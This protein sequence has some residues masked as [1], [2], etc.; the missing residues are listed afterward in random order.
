MP[1]LTGLQ[2]LSLKNVTHSGP[3]YTQLVSILINCPAL[4]TLVLDAIRLTNA[5]EPVASA[6]P[7]A[8]PL[9]SLTSLTLKTMPISAATIFTLLEA[10]RCT[11][12]RVD[13]DGASEHEQVREQAYR[14]IA[15]FSLATLTPYL[16]AGGR[17]RVVMFS[18]WDTLLSLANEFTTVPERL[19]LNISIG[20]APSFIN[21]LP[22]IL[23]SH[24]HASNA[25]TIRMEL[26]TIGDEE[27]EAFRAVLPRLRH[28]T[29]LQISECS[30]AGT[31]PILRALSS[32]NILADPN[33]PA[34]W[35]CPKLQQLFLRFSPVCFASDVLLEMVENRTEA[36]LL[37]EMGQ[38]TTGVVRM[39]SLKAWQAGMT[40]QVYQ[41]IRDLMGP[42]AICQWG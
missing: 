14:C 31:M 19:F 29:S 32:P 10:P 4:Q 9:H 20:G 27:L 42:E 23:D 17:L 1:I 2:T 41:H 37:D 8:I 11:K 34:F 21:A 35:I 5:T 30:S 15:A 33:G 28:V 18:D 38:E 16:N 24:D 7:A 12:I 13:L 36:A 25:L 26:D 40:V 6:G 3:S 22:L 39:T